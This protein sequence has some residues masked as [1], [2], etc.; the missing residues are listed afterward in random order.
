M[1]LV[2]GLPLADTPSF[3]KIVRKPMAGFVLEDA[4]EA[5]IAS[6]IKLAIYPFQSVVV[7][8][9]AMKTLMRELYERGA[10]ASLGNAMPAAKLEQ[11]VGAE[12]GSQLARHYGIV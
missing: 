2:T 7:A 9:Q 8:Y 1:L 11:L 12:A 4:M 10:L 3:A 6:A 5:V